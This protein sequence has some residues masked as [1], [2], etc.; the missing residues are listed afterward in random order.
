MKS[1]LVT[2][3]QLCKLSEAQGFRS[4]RQLSS[5]GSNTNKKGIRKQVILIAWYLEDWASKSEVSGLIS[6]PLVM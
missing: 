2:Q 6:V 4:G 1:V 5:A 3:Y